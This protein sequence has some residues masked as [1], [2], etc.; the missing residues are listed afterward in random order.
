MKK[1]LLAIVA[2]LFSVLAF[3]AVNINTATKEELDSLKGIGPVKAQAIVDY[4]TQNGPFKSVDDIRK[5]KGIGDKTF[6]EIKGDIA[7]S[8]VT[9]VKAAEPKKS[10]AAPAKKAE[11]AL[12][13]APAAKVTAPAA[14]AAASASSAAPAAKA[15]DVKTSDAKDKKAADKEAK[16]AEK[17]AEKAEKEAKKKAAKEEKTAKAEPKDEAKPADTAAKK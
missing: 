13:P 5:V 3:A 14:P 11:A 4:R 7:V 16:K 9:S 17:E 1:L 2:M 10:E 12:A 8:G 6:D 15:G